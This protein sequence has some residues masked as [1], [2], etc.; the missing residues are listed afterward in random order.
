MF[1]LERT[2]V[3]LQGQ[4]AAYNKVRGQEAR[5]SRRQL[6]VAQAQ[7]QPGKHYGHLG[8]VPSWL[9]VALLLVIYRTLP[10]GRSV[11]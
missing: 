6:V 8:K 10:S 1:T 3:G 5:R 2:R 9:P 11:H 7:C 4:Q